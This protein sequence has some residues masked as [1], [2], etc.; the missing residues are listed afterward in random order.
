MFIKV[1]MV[2]IHFITYENYLHTD[3]YIQ[4]NIVYIIF[5]IL[6]KTFIVQLFPTC[7]S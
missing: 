4:A 7:F 3:A 6:N 1:D 2:H 5:T